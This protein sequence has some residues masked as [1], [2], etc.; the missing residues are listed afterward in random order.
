MREGATP[1]RRLTIMLLCLL[2]GGGA[3]GCST[4]TTKTSGPIGCCCTYAI[5]RADLSQPECSKEGQFQG[6]T[7]T[8][9][10]GAC[11]EHDTYPAP[12]RPVPGR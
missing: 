7:S 2:A 8:W 4:M 11:T 6:W 12:D 1:R 5:C 3:A 9:H 10:P